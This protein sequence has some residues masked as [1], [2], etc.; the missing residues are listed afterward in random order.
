MTKQNVDINPQWRLISM[1]TLEYLRQVLK[2]QS[3]PNDSDEIKALRVERDKVEQLLRDNFKQSNPTIRYGGSMAKSTMIRDNYDL[4]IVCY[5]NHD[6][7]N[8]GETLEEIYNNVRISLESKYLVEPK[9]SALQLK[10]NDP[11]RY[12]V[13][14]HID[15]VP[16][17]FVDNKKEDTYLYQSSGEKNYLKT[18]LQTHI[19]HVI[20]SRLR[21]IIKMI[22]YW[23]VRN[24]LNI[25][26]FVLEL[27]IIKVLKKTDE[28]KIDICIRK[29][30]EELRDNIDTTN[31]EDPANPTGN[32]LSELFNESI[33]SMLSSEAKRALEAIDN[34]NWETVFG[35]VESMS[36]E[37]KLESIQIMRQ[38][39]PNSSKPWCNIT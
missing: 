3:L 13:Y 23:K 18:N 25:K 27:L 30:W 22:K 24:G 36:N 28:N 21:D 32:N 19:D 7:R 34:Q 17:R 9:T 37:E 26:T 2:Q 8:A 10:N 12:G 14:F 15:V 39:N 6:D 16:G 4:D 5:F 33:K 31:I 38:K 1:T 20:N 29:L 35:K 11:L